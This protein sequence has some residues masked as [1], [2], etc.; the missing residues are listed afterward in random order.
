V[1]L[2]KEGAFAA[3]GLKYRYSN[4]GYALLAI[5][6]ERV[7]GEDFGS[8]LDHEI[9]KP[10]GMSNTFLYA[11]QCDLTGVFCTSGSE[12][13][14]TLEERWYAHQAIQAFAERARHR[15]RRSGGL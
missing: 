2:N 6:V 15:R 10:A 4:P 3:P 1:L 11:G 5:V 8:F 9:F 13:E 14:F 7:S 12:R